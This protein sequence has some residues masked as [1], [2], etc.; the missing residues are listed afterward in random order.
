MDRYVGEV[1]RNGS[2]LFQFVPIKQE[3]IA[4]IRVFRTVEKGMVFTFNA[5]CI[6]LFKTIQANSFL[7]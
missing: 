6:K 4:N 2:N 5:S 7:L 3:I 1:Y